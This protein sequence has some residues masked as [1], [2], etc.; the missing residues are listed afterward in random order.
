MTANL[1]E[2]L[3]SKFIELISR[4]PAESGNRY[5][6]TLRE[7]VVRHPVCTQA[8]IKAVSHELPSQFT[9]L[10]QQQFYESVP[11]AWAIGAGVPLC[12]HCGNAMKPGKAGLVCRTLA[13]RAAHETDVG[14]YADSA[15]LLRV[16]RGVRQYW[17]E[18]GRDE[19]EM[20]DILRADGLDVALYPHR[21]R[22]DL[23][24]GEIGVDLK[25]Y[26]S[27]ETLGRRFQKG[28]GG[29]AH[30]ARKLVVIPDWLTKS[31]PSYLDRLRSAGQ[32][33]ELV[34]VTV[35]EAIRLIRKEAA[36]A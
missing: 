23:A 11:D 36:R 18:P 34:F 29:L 8:Q 3:F 21:D 31:T 19:I 28:I 2:Q 1:E 15:T 12:Q 4:Y 9:V 33:P 10:L 24:V 13:C 5:Y 35:T 26:A 20:C 17:I 14:L 27:P 32:R 30:Y 7:F 16:T 22:V 25:M 6:T